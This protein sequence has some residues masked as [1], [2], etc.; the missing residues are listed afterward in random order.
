VFYEFRLQARRRGGAQD[1]LVRQE[2]PKIVRYAMNYL[3]SLASD[4]YRGLVETALRAERE[5]GRDKN[6][7]GAKTNA[8]T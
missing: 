6:N 3:K 5:R 8:P 1:R 2:V 7:D 4:N